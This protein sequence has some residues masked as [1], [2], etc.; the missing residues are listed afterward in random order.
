MAT[1]DYLDL[2]KAYLRAIEDGATGDRLASF[3]T[4]DVV[5]EEFPNRLLPQGAR[6]NLADLLSGAERGQA[7]MASQRYELSSAV[8]QGAKVALEVQWTATLRRPVPGLPEGSMRARFGVFLV[9][10]DDKI[11][12]QRNYDCFEPW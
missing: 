2:A 10:R 8:V 9:F 5:Q 6:R 3:F 4:P 12:E 7:I 1:F 11:A